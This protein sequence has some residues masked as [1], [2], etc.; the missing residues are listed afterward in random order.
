VRQLV[1]PSLA[2]FGRAG[3]NAVPP[4]AVLVAEVKLIGAADDD[5]ARVTR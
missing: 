3:S 1:I 4:N 5:S 2:G